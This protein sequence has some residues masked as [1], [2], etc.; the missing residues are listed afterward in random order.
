M[1]YSGVV[2]SVVVR[3]PTTPVL[4]GTFYD[5]VASSP[6]AMVRIEWMRR[7]ARTWDFHNTWFSR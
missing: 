2:I 4:H 6:E 7:Y 1:G 5:S 3:L